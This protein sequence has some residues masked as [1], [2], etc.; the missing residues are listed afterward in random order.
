[1]PFLVKRGIDVGFYILKYRPQIIAAVDQ[2]TDPIN[3]FVDKLL[4]YF[5]PGDYGKVS[6]VVL[7]GATKAFLQYLEEKLDIPQEPENLPD[8]S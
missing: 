5:K 6:S 1:M 7:L 3:T 8:E 4:D 2:P